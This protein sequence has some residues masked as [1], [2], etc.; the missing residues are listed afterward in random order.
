MFHRRWLLQVLLAAAERLQDYDE[1][2]RLVAVKA[3]C[4]A[5]KQLL[6]GP[7]HTPTGPKGPG[8]A[9]TAAV[10]SPVDALLGSLGES[11]ELANAAA[12]DLDLDAA[13]DLGTPG[14]AVAAA[15]V[16]DLPFV[17]EVLRR[18]YLRLRDTKP[19]VRKAAASHFLSIFRAVVSAGGLADSL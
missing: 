1:K 9:N 7:T 15:A 18:V 10:L 4:Q 3:V 12:A 16:R 6:V 19:A 5:A 17:H 11:Q 13:A 2:V 14:A 8:S